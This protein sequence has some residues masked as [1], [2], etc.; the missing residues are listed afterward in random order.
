MTP[1]ELREALQTS[2]KWAAD[3]N[4]G[5]CFG[6]SLVWMTDKPPQ[7]YKIRTPF[8]N[9]EIMN[10]QEKDGRYQTVFRATKKQI[11]NY[12]K[13]CEAVEVKK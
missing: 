10:C 8:G 9:C 5:E 4:L 11:L 3:N 6:L 7:G 12:L 1:N 2:D 13:K